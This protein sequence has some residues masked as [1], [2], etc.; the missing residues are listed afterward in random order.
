METRLAGHGDS[1]VIWQVWFWS[2]QRGISLEGHV[3]Q[4]VS[5]SESDWI[6]FGIPLLAM[7]AF[8]FFRLDEVFTSRRKSSLQSRLSPSVPVRKGRPLGTDPDGRAWD[9][10]PASKK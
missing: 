10:A 9:D 7:L 6:F 5:H 1:I 8:S 3:N 2:R 4:T